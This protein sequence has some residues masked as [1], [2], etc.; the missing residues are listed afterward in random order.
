MTDKSYTDAI[1]C[2]IIWGENLRV[3]WIPLKMWKPFGNLRTW[4]FSVR[5][6][7]LYVSPKTC[8]QV[9]VLGFNVAVIVKRT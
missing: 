3:A 5:Y 9:S 1:R 4:L 6:T 8:V 2:K 7:S